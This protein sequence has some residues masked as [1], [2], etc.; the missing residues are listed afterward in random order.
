MFQMFNSWGRPRV[1]SDPRPSPHTVIYQ[2]GLGYQREDKPYWPIDR[3]TFASAL[4]EKLAAAT[5]STTRLVH[6]DGTS[7][8][9]AVFLDL[10]IV[11]E[12][13]RLA[14]AMPK[15]TT[16]RG[17]LETTIEANSR[18]ER[19]IREELDF[20]AL[21]AR[22]V[23]GRSIGF[24]GPERS[25]HAPFNGPQMYYPGGAKAETHWSEDKRHVPFV[26]RK[27]VVGG[28]YY[29]L[30]RAETV[31]LAKQLVR[32]NLTHGLRHGVLIWSDDR[33]A[34]DQEAHLAWGD[35]LEGACH[36]AEREAMGATAD[37]GP[38]TA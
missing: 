35:E 21:T 36:A 6:P 9:G 7:E 8:D 30:T 33:T 1:V 24:T 37:A 5:L 10:E 26:W 18:I 2:R 11:P 38:A 32:W 16:A 28:V 12:W 3:R 25:V 20:A 4:A 22:Y 29:T 13:R 19:E 14:R 23:T 34:A 15:Q 31:A 17:K 27:K